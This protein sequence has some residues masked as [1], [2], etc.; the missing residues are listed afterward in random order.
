MHG[1]HVH[2]LPKAKYSLRRLINPR[3]SVH[4]S[5]EVTL[6][7]FFLSG[8]R[9]AIESALQPVELPRKLLTKPWDSPYAA[10][11]TEAAAS[12][13]RSLAK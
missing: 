9:V 11:C 1:V 4:I 8:N 7:L 13:V 3:G 10:H 5:L 2:V 12:Y 6:A